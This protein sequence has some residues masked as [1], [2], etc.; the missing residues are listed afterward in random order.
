MSL[1]SNGFTPYNMKYTLFWIGFRLIDVVISTSKLIVLHVFTHC[2]N[3]VDEKCITEIVKIRH[4]FRCEVV[5][6]CYHVENVITVTSLV[7][8]TGSARKCVTVSSVLGFI[9]L[10]N[11]T[12]YMPIHT[13][14]IRACVSTVSCVSFCNFV[15]SRYKLPN[16]FYHSFCSHWK[17]C[18]WNW[19]LPLS[20]AQNPFPF[21]SIDAPTLS[22]VALFSP[23]HSH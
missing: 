11:E 14:F 20:P 7:S 8:N 23:S 18:F 22:F 4:R 17:Y 3:S 6:N 1:P 15:A 5:S 13:F 19:N 21:S 2:H 10:G 9:S 12:T 16:S